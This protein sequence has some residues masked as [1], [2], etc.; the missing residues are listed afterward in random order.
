MPNEDRDD[1][2]CEI[3]Y[4][5]ASKKLLELVTSRVSDKSFVNLFEK[6]NGKVLIRENGTLENLKTDKQTPLVR[7][8]KEREKPASAQRENRV[9]K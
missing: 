7:L 1:E 9:V 5:I 6:S 3:Y 2:F 8:E 4:E